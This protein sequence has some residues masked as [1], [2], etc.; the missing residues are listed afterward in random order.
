MAYVED[1]LVFLLRLHAP[2]G[3]WTGAEFRIVGKAEIDYPSR[4]P[5]TSDLT[6]CETAD[7]SRVRCASGLAAVNSVRLRDIL[8]QKEAV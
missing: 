6:E 2:K 5:E 1:G 4:F 8:T 7:V 3:D